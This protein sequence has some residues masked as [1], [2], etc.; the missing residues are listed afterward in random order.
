[1]MPSRA[2]YEYNNGFALP[3]GGDDC[4]SDDFLPGDSVDGFE[5]LDSFEQ[6]DFD[7]W[8]Q[9]VA[10]IN[11]EEADLEC[12]VDSMSLAEVR[13]ELARRANKMNE[14]TSSVHLVYD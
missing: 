11:R 8:E 12:D 13:A 6:D 7:T 4:E 10:A 2:F 3:P 1:M 9:W 5:P 14:T